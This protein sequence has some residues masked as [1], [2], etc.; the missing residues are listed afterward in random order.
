MDEIH[1]SVQRVRATLTRGIKRSNERVEKAKKDLEE[2]LKGE[3]IENTNRR[4]E[5]RETE[6]RHPRS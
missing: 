6:I 1:Q 4:A 3:V 5:R 2:V